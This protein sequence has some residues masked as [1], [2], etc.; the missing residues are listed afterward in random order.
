MLEEAASG[1]LLDVEHYNALLSVYLENGHAFSHEHML[2]RL[3]KNGVKANKE[4]FRAL[5]DRYC[6]LG[7][8]D[9][10]SNMLKVL[11]CLVF[12]YAF[13]AIVVLIYSHYLMFIGYLIGTTLIMSEFITLRRL[14]LIPIPS[15][16]GYNIYR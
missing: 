1:P 16:V 5:L 9:G 6:Q 14:I 7:D 3:K 11:T 2:L 13:M 8:M 10:A 15:T 4:T 12:I